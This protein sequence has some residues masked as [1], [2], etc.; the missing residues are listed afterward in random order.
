MTAR[1]ARQLLL[2]GSY[3]TA[4][5]LCAYFANFPVALASTISTAWLGAIFGIV[6]TYW[7]STYSEIRILLRFAIIGLLV[8]VAFNF[9]ATHLLASHALTWFLIALANIG[10]LLIAA[11]LGVL[12]ARGLKR[13]SYLM[14]AVIVGALTD[15][16]SVYAGPSNQVI[17][18]SYFPYLSFQWPAIGR[19]IIP[20]VGAGDFIFLALFF[21][22]SRRFRL[23]SRKTLLAM[24]IA[25][26]VGFF[27]LLI[28]PRGVP[29]LPFMAVFLLLVHGSELKK[30]MR[31]E[32]LENRRED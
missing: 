4:F 22:G 10:V 3:F 27:S 13:P 32:R 6:F 28:I 17:G 12:I 30:R 24:I 16:F 2:C 18:S 26:G 15:I 11:A 20:C 14:M 9:A 29:A 21:A 1:Q 23:D 7:F 5:F 19:G 8:D 25:I 31:A